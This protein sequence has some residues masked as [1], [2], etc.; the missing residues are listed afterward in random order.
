MRMLLRISAIRIAIAVFAAA[1]VLSSL[2]RGDPPLPAIGAGTY[3][4][5]AYGAVADGVTD[6]TTAIQAALDAAK[7][8][9]GTV[10][11]PAGAHEYRSGPLTVYGGTR[12][13][14]DAGATLQALPFG[15]Y[16]KSTSAPAHFITIASGATNV[17][18]SG[19]GVID[20]NGSDW[21][22]AYSSGRITSRPRLIQVNHADTVRIA[23]VTL[24][25]S[26][27]FHVAFSATNNV[28]ID[29]VTITA[30]ANSPNTDAIDPAG[31]HYLIKNCTVSVGDDNVA[32]KA[33]S[34]FCGDIVVT[35]CAFGT[36][37]GVSIGGQTN[38]GVDG[39]TVDDCTFDGT[40]TALRLK[41]DPTQ[42]GPVQN[43]TY[44]NL[45][46]TNVTYPFVFYS[47][48]REVGSPGAVSGSN[49]TTP[50]KV[51]S[52]NA[53]PPDALN[54]A[55]IPT[56][57]NIT[58]SNITATGATGYSIIWGLPLAD[59][60]IENVTLKNVRISGSA[61]LELYNATNVQ[62]V[63]GT[64]FSVPSN[65]TPLTT[66]NALAVTTQPRNLSVVTGG[67]ATFTAAVA[68]PG[69]TVAVAP[70]LQW[71]FNGA[72]LADGTQPDGAI[73]SG[74]TTGT[75]TIRA[76]QA[77]DAGRYALRAT[78]AFDTYD[79]AAGTLVTGN[80]PVVV[81]S[82][83]AE[84]V[85]GAAPVSALTNLSIRGPAGTGDQ[86]LIV[87]FVVSGTGKPVLV[88]AVGPT[89]ATFSVSGVM[90]DPRLVVHTADGVVATNDNWGSV[91]TQPVLDSVSHD[92]G[93]FAL[94][95]NSL[96]AALLTTA[97]NGVYTAEVTGNAGT[98]VALAEIYDAAPLT[99]AR[100]VNLSARGTVGT[101]DATM[102]AG[103][104]IRGSAPRTVL[105]RGVGPG[106]AAYG[107][108]T[109]LADPEL[110][111]VRSSDHAQIAA[112][113]DWGSI[114]TNPDVAAAAK[115]VGA[116]ALLDGTK[117]AALLLTL[118]PGGYTAQVDGVG[119]T[120]GVALVE[121]YDVR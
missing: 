16:P 82:A 27:M 6:N 70:R 48:Y 5:T 120:G 18:I 89:L 22:T 93:A 34:T 46:L 78:T 90:A 26:P 53:V 11:L 54:A 77:K 81:T 50:A 25:N 97:D 14:V 60:L 67:T 94:P 57:K 41:A 121:V 68:G 45:T 9:G 21:W 28:T 72:P 10:R 115:Q 73:V 84:L 106:L 107:L 98:G 39:F 59:A 96:D 112:N 52:W 65:A 117:D 109:A 4:V 20:G 13:A 40:T 19:G 100:L 102:I 111:V 55:T 47:Y 110:T 15:T 76:V 33:S 99:P 32:V 92:L 49:A 105:I 23:G 43:V 1:P 24:A 103:F 80:A 30:P 29:G 64:E 79:T 2:V 83:D 35:H 37:H 17:E 3:D 63:G 69:E 88:R 104:V 44:S 119:N 38:A 86:T 95:D 87:G 108:T 58:L 51:A 75:L 42:G 114:A 12:L 116:F 85:V 74:S 61:G 71:L 56:W 31:Q 7:A 118:P 62:F 113:N 36:G 8:G 66:Y 91:A 101:G